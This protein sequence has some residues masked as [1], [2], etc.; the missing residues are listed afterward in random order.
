M[1][2]KRKSSERK[3]ILQ[4][5]YYRREST[6]F[7]NVSSKQKILWPT[8]RS[9]WNRKIQK[10]HTTKEPDNLDHA[11]TENTTTYYMYFPPT[12]LR[13]RNELAIQWQATAAEGQFGYVLHENYESNK[14]DEG[15]IK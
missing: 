8:A 14:K 9:Y 15:N 5:R 6:F 4:G 2:I 7:A 12:L 1:T 3:T 11:V 13:S 10:P